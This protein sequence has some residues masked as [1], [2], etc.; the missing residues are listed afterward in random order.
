MV[1]EL[2]MNSM[3]DKT[4]IKPVETDTIVKDNRNDFEKYMSYNYNYID[5]VIEVNDMFYVKKV[6]SI[7]PHFNYV[8]CGVEISNMSNR[9]MNKVFSCADD[10]DIKTYY[11]DTDS[12][13]LNYEDVDK[14]ENGYK[15]EYGSELIC[16]ELGNLHI[17][18]SM[19]KANTEIYAVESLFLGK[20]NLHRYVRIN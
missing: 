1:I 19:G 9:I 4:I 3:Y 8:H 17:D 18:F 11:Q 14:I 16:E 10:C 2:L 6:K 20:R 13:H 7:L 12:I 5:S 15:E